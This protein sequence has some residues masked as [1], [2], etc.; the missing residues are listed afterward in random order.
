MNALAEVEPPAVRASATGRALLP[1]AARR[2]YSAG[3]LIALGIHAAVFFALPPSVPVVEQV[4]FGVE[5]AE[6]SVEVSLVAAPPAEEPAAVIDAPP[7]PE[8]RPL[9]EPRPVVE[10]P[11]VEPV[12]QPEMALPEP[13]PPK[14]AKPNAEAKPVQK[15]KPIARA[16]RAAGDGSSAVAGNDATTAVASSGAASAKPSY[17]RNPHPAYPEAARAAKQQGV[18]L[19]RVGVTAQGAV[20]NVRIVR[21]SGFPLLDERARSTVAERWSFRPAKAGGVAVASEVSIP[22]RFTLVR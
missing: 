20:G 15:R 10:P 7:E 14:P 16:A 9:P 5:T 18:V 3:L 1:A 17:L 11:P 13:A 21:S 4:E 6:A 2:N 22:I 8:P 12:A 19:L